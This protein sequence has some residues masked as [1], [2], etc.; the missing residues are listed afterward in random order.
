MHQEGIIPLDLQPFAG[1]RVSGARGAAIPLHPHGVSGARGAAGF[2]GAAGRRLRAAE[3]MGRWHTCH[4]LC[5]LQHLLCK[6]Q[7]V[8]IACGPLRSTSQ[9]KSVAH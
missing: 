6:L 1:P 7:A 3:D 5:T 8:Q 9:E 2:D 4:P